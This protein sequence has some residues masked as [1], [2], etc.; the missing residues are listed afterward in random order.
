MTEEKAP[1][2]THEDPLDQVKASFDYLYEAAAKEIVARLDDPKKTGEFFNQAITAHMTV[3]ALRH[4]NTVAGRGVLPEEANR[5]K[6]L[7]AAYL[8]DKQIK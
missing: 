1:H 6:D 8:K 5:L 4:L 2:R 7:I 3:E